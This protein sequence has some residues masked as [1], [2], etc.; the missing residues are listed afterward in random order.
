ME[1]QISYGSISIANND[2]FYEK[3]KDYD[4]DRGNNGNVGRDRPEISS[5]SSY[6]EY[7]VTYLLAPTLSFP[8]KLE[9]C[10][11]FTVPLLIGA[12]LL[13]A[14]AMLFSSSAVRC[15]GY[16]TDPKFCFQKEDTTTPTTP[17]LESATTKSI[18][19]QELTFTSKDNGNV[20]SSATTTYATTTAAK[21]TGQNMAKDENHHVSAMSQS[22]CFQNS[23]CQNL[24]LQGECCPTTAGV[25]LG[26]C[27]RPTL[28]KNDPKSTMQSARDDQS[29]SSCASN[30]SCYFLGLLGD[31]C[32]TAK[33]I[34]LSCC[35]S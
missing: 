21:Y 29:S 22:M 8:Q 25:Y 6:Q 18:P 3:A 23:Q 31:C 20:S 26:C 19:N 12:M 13:W 35:H 5:F 15:G 10:F 33:G 2:H 17:N 11:R 14:A 7:D 32:P 30:P 27:S 9:R 28:A 4:H 16:P 24:G 1:Q 34:Q